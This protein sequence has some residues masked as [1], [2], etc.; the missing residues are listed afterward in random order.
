MSGQKVHLVE[1][2]PGEFRVWFEEPRAEPYGKYIG[3]VASVYGDQTWV[4]VC[5][6]DYEGNAM[7]NRQALPSLIKAL[8]R[9]ERHLAK[10]EK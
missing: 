4:H 10:T 9:V 1:D 7:I 6:D 2:K 8:Q 5:T 3:P